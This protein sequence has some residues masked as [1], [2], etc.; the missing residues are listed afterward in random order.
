MKLLMFSSFQSCAEVRKKK[1]LIS[2]ISEFFFSKKSK[3]IK[4]DF[5]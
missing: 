5:L 3:K 2:M 4:N 1:Y